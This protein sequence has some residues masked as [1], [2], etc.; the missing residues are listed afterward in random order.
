[1]TISE[2]R[3]LPPFAIG[4]LGASATPL[5]NFDL[6]PDD[7]NALGFRQITGA[8]TFRV[9][10]ETGEIKG[11]TGRTDP[12]QGRRRDS[13]GGALPRGFRAHRGRHLEPLTLALLDKHKLTPAR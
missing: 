10:R 11:A 3:I 2:I 5:E 8:E 9:D 13:A 4:R 6:V 12:V 1:M 7:N